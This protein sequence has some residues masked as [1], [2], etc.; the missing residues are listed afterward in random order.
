MTFP[1]AGDHRKQHWEDVYSAKASNEVSWYQSIPDT[2]LSLIRASKAGSAAGSA[3]K[4]IDIGGGASTL[5]DH[6][7]AEGFRDVTVLD[8]SEAAIE[9]A[10]QRLGTRASQIH[11]LVADIVSWRPQ[12]RYDLWHDRAVF[13]FLTNPEDRRAYVAALKATLRPGGTVILATFAPDGPER[14]SGLP[15]CRYSPEMLAAELGAELTLVQ[16]IAEDH[17]TPSGAVQ[18]FIYC[19]FTR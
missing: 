10:R 12:T 17:H 13:H 3:A 14:C 15:V 11:W 4:I 7:L 9:Q 16:T 6:L 8:I 5:A 19:R 2:S 1:L 18:P